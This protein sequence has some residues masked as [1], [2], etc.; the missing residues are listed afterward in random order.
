MPGIRLPIWVHTSARFYVHAHART[1]TCRPTPG[2]IGPTR[3]L[4]CAPTAGQ[5]M[6]SVEIFHGLRRIPTVVGSRHPCVRP[7]SAVS[8]MWTRDLV[9]SVCVTTVAP[10]MASVAFRDQCH[11]EG[12]AI[13]HGTTGPGPRPPK[14]GHAS[15]FRSTGALGCFDGNSGI[16]RSP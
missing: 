13:G 15:C 6:R 11:P 10:T 3:S 7:R 5:T 16:D 14:T 2:Y 9:G 1:P 4:A 12:L 8:Y